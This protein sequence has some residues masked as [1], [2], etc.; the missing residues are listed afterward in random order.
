MKNWLKENLVLAI[1]LTLPLLLILLFFVA[2]VLPKS[3]GQPPQ[4]EML[5]TIVKYDYQ[6]KPEYVFDFNVKNQQLMVKTKKYDEKNNTNSSRILM[7]YDGKTETTREI[8]IDASKFSD[9]AEVVLE[10][11]KDM[12]IDASIVSPDGYTLSGPNYSSGGLLGG[13]LMGGYN[14]NGGYSIKKGG[15]G[16]KVSGLLPEYYYNQLQFVG[17]VVKK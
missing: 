11:T 12:S 9:G 8:K 13:L 7:A 16:Y 5:F 4:Y 1:G 3:F 15:V 2:T 10:E 17:W 14:S 6:I